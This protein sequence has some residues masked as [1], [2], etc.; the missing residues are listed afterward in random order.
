MLSQRLD[1]YASATDSTAYKALHNISIPFSGSIGDDVGLFPIAFLAR[2]Q[3]Y[4]NHPDAKYDNTTD[5]QIAI[6]I[7]ERNVLQFPRRLKD[8]CISRAG[9]WGGEKGDNNSFVW[10]D[11]QFMGL[12]VLFR[13]AKLLNNQQYADAAAEWLVLF[14]EHLF[15]QDA[16]LYLHGY[17]D[18]DHK[19]S[20]CK[21]SRA[22]GWAMM[23]HTEALLA[24]KQFPNTPNKQQLLSTFAAHAKGAAKVQS[25][26]GLWH[27]VV[28][29]DTTFLET[30]VTAMFLY[31]LVNGVENDWVDRATFQ[32]VIEK[33]WA[34]LTSTIQPNGSVNGICE[35]TGIGTDVAFYQAR[36]TAYGSSQ[37]GLGSVIRAIAAMG[38]FQKLLDK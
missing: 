25:T 17:N 11:D 31:S 23:A 19:T 4:K 8:G 10:A 35:G 30:S 18:Y 29:V 34:G 15:S 14:D 32:P 28:D 27:E 1:Q 33:A 6:R 36:S 26:Q 16:G 24:L 13:L 5:L 12:T 9:G 7:A 3:Y 2:L 21:W 37:P 22:N 20:C 38:N